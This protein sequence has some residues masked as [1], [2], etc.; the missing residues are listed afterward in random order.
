MTR[1]TFV[2]PAWNPRPVWIHDAVASILS[3]TG[4]AVELIVVDDGSPNPVESVLDHVSDSRLQVLRIPHAGSAAARNEGLSAATG[5]FVRFVDCDDVITPGSTQQLLDLTAGND[6]VVT[7][8]AS[9]F[10]AADLKPVWTMTSSVQGDAT[11]DCLLGRFAVRPGAL[12]FPRAVLERVGDWNGE[13]AI[14]EDWDFVLRV[15]EHASVRG[16]HHPV[17]LYRE[18]GSNLHGDLAGGLRDA[19][20]VVHLYFERHPERRGTSLETSANAAL[21]AHAARALLSRRCFRAGVRELL[22]LGRHPGAAIDQIRGGLPALAGHGRRWM[23]R[24][25]PERR[26]GRDSG[27]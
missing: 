11:T 18:H 8:G 17:L 16:T 24:F 20:R 23:G 4:V 2:M 9:V 26:G 15:L 3:Q 22:P 19:R 10:C 5:E 12:L 27:R 13:F 6:D 7:Y 1:V 25:V 21:H 14:S